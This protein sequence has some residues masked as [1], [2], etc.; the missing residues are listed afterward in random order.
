VKA[1]LITILFSV[2]LLT[3]AEAHAQG[4]LSA[5]A[6]DGSYAVVATIGG[7][8]AR[9]ITPYASGIEIDRTGATVSARLLWYPD[10]RLRMGVES[11]WTRFYSYDLKDVATSFGTTDASLSLSA[12]PLVAVFSMSLGGSVTLYAG[13]GGYFVRS[14][15][16]SFGTT[17]DVTRFSQG[18]MAAISWDHRITEALRLGAELKWYGATE[19]GDGVVTLQLCVPITLMRW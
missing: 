18:W 17:V 13:A 1:I 4:E 5:A 7:G 16:S 6:V 11:G 12:I 3:F 15:A 19:F 10:H 8:Y 14:H 2:P 9:Y